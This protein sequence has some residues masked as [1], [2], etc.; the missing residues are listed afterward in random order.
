MSSRSRP[1][2]A[3]A[4]RPPRRFRPFVEPLEERWLPSTFTVNTTGDSPLVLINPDGSTVTTLRAA[5]NEVNADATDSAASPDTIAFNIPQTD[6]GYNPATGVWT[7][8]P[9]SALPAITQPV[10]I[11]GIT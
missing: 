7:I 2:K 9:Q 1:R 3:T 11:N 8:A 10:A 4:A 5:I 6:T